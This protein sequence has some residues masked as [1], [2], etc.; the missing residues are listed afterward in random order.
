LGFG[1]IDIV[2]AS[3]VPKKFR[4]LLAIAMQ[5]FTDPNDQF[6]NTPPKKNSRP[7]HRKYDKMS[8]ICHNFNQHRKAHSVIYIPF[9]FGNLDVLI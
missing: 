6:A 4:L 8:E 7:I 2:S 3:E 9:Q 1:L 5:H